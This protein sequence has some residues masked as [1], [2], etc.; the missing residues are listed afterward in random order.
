MRRDHTLPNASESFLADLKLGRPGAFAS[1]MH[2]NNRRLWRIARAILRNESDAEE[3]VQ[4][5]YMR[6]FTHMREFRGEAKL[7]TWLSKI[8]VNEALKIRARRTEIVDIADVAE[9][10]PSDHAGGGLASPEQESGRRELRLLLEHAIDGLA[11]PFRTVFVMRTIEELSVEEIAQCLGVHSI[12]VRTRFYR[13]SRQL[14]AV[15]GNKLASGFEDAFPFG[16]TQCERLTC[17]VFV[18]LGLVPPASDRPAR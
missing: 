4:E 16:G 8:V 13:A 7:S 3:A 15:L 11:A 9:S 10:L 12:T 5:A 1:L 2:Q 17:S 6:A 18:R 14:R